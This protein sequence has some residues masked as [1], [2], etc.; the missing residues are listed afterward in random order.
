M[1]KIVYTKT[2]EKDFKKLDKSVVRRIIDK[3]SETAENPHNFQPL[4][5]SPKNLQNLYK[6]RAGD[7]RILFWI[8]HEN[9]TIILYI[10]EHRSKIYKNF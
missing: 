1:Y 2:F 6:L 10:I 5:Y 8:D 9:K 7:W 4:K 3:I